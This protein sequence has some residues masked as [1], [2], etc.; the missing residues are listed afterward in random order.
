MQQKNSKCLLL[1][2]DFS[3]ITIIDWRKAIHLYYQNRD[4][5][6]KTIE[7]ID[8]YKNDHISGVNNKKYPVPAVIALKKYIKL[9]NRI[10]F[11]RKNLF[12][13]DNHTCQYCSKKCEEKELTYD[14]V[15]PK[16]KWDYNKGSPT[17]WTNITTACTT[18]NRKKGNKTPHQAKM[19]L[20]TIPF[21]PN[22]NLN[23]LRF[24]H[25]LSTIADR[26]PP[27]WAVYLPDSYRQI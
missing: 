5:S 25:L 14:H 23:H 13:R 10:I 26:M 4:K 11:S 20:L 21:M 3:P 16:S 7:I 22:K 15:I 12:L 8:F 6:I 27:E 18:C 19:S 9:N 2:A 17:N 24:D 1:N